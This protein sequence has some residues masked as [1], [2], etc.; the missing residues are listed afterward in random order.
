[1]ESL[2]SS[3]KGKVPIAYSSVCGIQREDDNNK[4]FRFGV[5]PAT[6]TLN[7]KFLNNVMTTLTLLHNSNF[8]YSIECKFLLNSLD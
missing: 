5:E 4:S 6:I 1:M 2:N 8:E 7:N 3:V